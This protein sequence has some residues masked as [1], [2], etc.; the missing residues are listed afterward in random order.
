[1]LA[2]KI[3]EAA[4]ALEM[5]VIAEGIETA[6]EFHWLRENGANLIQGFYLARPSAVPVSAVSLPR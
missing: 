6:E 3:I 5:T 2:G 4:R 1:M